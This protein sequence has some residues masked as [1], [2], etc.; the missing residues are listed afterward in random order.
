MVLFI[1]GGTSIFAREFTTYVNVPDAGGLVRGAVVRS[2]GLRI[3]RVSDIEFSPTI[4]HE[5]IAQHYLALENS[6]RS[7]RIAKLVNFRDGIAAYGA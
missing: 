7:L 5:F 2:G 4:L 6:R 1:G 3:G